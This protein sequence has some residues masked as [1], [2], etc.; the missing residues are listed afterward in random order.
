LSRGV[1][2]FLQSTLRFGNPADP[3]TFECQTQGVPMSTVA[4]ESP[5]Q[6]SEAPDTLETSETLETHGVASELP[7]LPLTTGVVLPHMVV[8]I[9]LETEESRA[10]AEAA[11][12]TDRELLLVP[13]IEGR[14]AT[15]GVVAQIETAG[16]LPTGQK[17]LVVRALRRVRLGAAIASPLPAGH[18]GA[19]AM[20]LHAATIEPEL[21]SDSVRA[22]AREYRQTAEAF[23]ERQ[24][25]G[26]LAF[27]LI[28]ADD[29]SAL[30][31]GI[32][33][34]PDL[35]PEQRIELLETPGTTA[36]LELA[37]G[38]VRTAMAESELREKI[39]TDV[40]AGM[41][42]QQRE[43]LL[44]QQL[45]AIRKELGEDGDGS[46]A[47]ETYRAKVEAAN[48]PTA[49]R[50]AVDKEIDKLERLGEQNPEQAYVRNWLDTVLDIA[51]STRSV[52]R[53]DIAAARAVLDHDTTGLAEGKE[54]ILEWLAVRALRERQRIAEAGLAA[55]IAE[56]ADVPAFDPVLSNTGD[57][58]E[59]NPAFTPVGPII[60][61][62]TGP[63]ATAAS[64]K[65]QGAII[66]LVGPPGVGKTSLGESI[67]RALD[68]S[69]VRV[70]LGGVRDEAE[71]RG[72]RRTYVGAQSGRIVRALRE[73]KT[74]NPVILLDEIDK[75]ATGWSGDPAAA[76]LEV[77]DPAQNHTFRDHYLEVDL[78][79]SDVVFI[80]TANSLETIPGPLRDRLEIITVDGY[81][82]VEK[83]DIVRNHLLARQL[84]ANG[85]RA[86]DV[87]IGD[88]AIRAI[89]EGYTMEAGV[90]GLERQVGKLLRKVAVRIAAGSGS[91][92][93]S[94]T[95]GGVG[96]AA[97]VADADGIVPVLATHGIEEGTPNASETGAPIVVGTAADVIPFL[98]R[99]RRTPSTIADRLSLPGV[100]T[101]LAVTGV[102]G[103]VL[104]VEATAMPQSGTD[105]GVTVTG[106][107]G[108]VMQESAQI[109][110]SYVRANAEALGVS[111]EAFTG[112][113]IHIHFPAGATPKD[114]PSAGITMTTALVSLL[115][116]RTVRNDVAMTGEVTL[117]GQV[118][119]I[120]G[121]KQK[122]LAAHRAGVKTVII[123]KQN[124]VDLDDVPPGLLADLDVFPVAHVR[125]VLDIALSA[126]Q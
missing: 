37:L 6:A 66:A 14:F 44:R 86:D 81:T 28:D 79:L 52:D 109:A 39:R 126:A 62:A 51:W 97:G 4:Q 58:G 3:Q 17:A 67:A 7:L 118:L 95:P 64:R 38:W 61:T 94:G 110:L 41:E 42:K 119:P 11:M 107:L 1:E 106:Q 125:E 35:E 26:R 70:A 56:S 45:S 27:Q 123:P 46:S 24:T 10:A 100:A 117:Q 71:I 20:W 114:G 120:G 102:G 72:H 116:G 25:A 8:T 23:L 113:K 33:Y 99:P 22:L 40:A 49:I 13:R 103:D 121:V 105:V 83:V 98:G 18:P 73:A 60:G 91:A 9:A 36:R 104:F 87:S 88:E 92:G 89:V 32:V 85:L 65:G 50:E 47:A 75:L 29:P 31:D 34:W 59:A 54:R 12:S 48:L 2:S 124:E 111:A 43:Y 84:V 93:G 15:V 115:T 78:D 53:V 69:F 63:I 82:D 19:A 5:N 57:R 77:L 96:E 122:L 108:D 80:A 21:L 68:R 30:A 76:L 112:R 55:S 74:M 90:R 16:E 101:G